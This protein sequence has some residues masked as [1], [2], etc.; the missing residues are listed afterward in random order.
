[1]AKPK[2]CLLFGFL[3]VNVG[4]VVVDPP[5]SDRAWY[6]K[7][8]SIMRDSTVPESARADAR[9]RIEDNTPRLL[10]DVKSTNNTVRFQSAQLLASLGRPE[11]LAPLL[12][13]SY[14]ESSGERLAAFSDLVILSRIDK[15]PAHREAIRA[16]AE[17][18]LKAGQLV[19]CSCQI[20]AIL[21]DQ[22]SLPVLKAALGKASL[23]GDQDDIR[24]A[25]NELENKK[26]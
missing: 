14:S 17:T 23:P 19:S 26:S 25:I 21:H 22:R 1:M 15:I 2:S 8:L 20:L 11:A 24:S 3:V 13:M 6:A 9:K 7:D 16:R 10:E 5:H 18:A 12:S 4:C